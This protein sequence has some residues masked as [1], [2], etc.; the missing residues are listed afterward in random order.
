MS[1]RSLTLIVVL[2][3]SV[4][5][6][7][8]GMIWGQ[9]STATLQGVIIDP[10]GTLVPR[11]VVKVQ[12][13]GTGLER[14]TQTEE[15]GTY[16]L[17]FLPV[18]AYTVIVEASGFKQARVQNVVLEIGQTRTLD[19]R[20]EVGEMQ[21]T[22]DV[23]ET[24]PPL[25][26]NSAVIGTVIQ[27]SQVK[28][29]PLN[30]RHWASLMMLAP[31]AINT[32]EGNQLSIRFVGRARDDNN[33]T[34]DSVDAT[35]AKDPRQETAVRLIISMDAISEFRVNSTLY[36]ADSGSGAGGQVQLIS[37]GGTNRFHGSVFE[38][39]RNDAFD[40]RIFTDPG[41]LPPFRLNQ[42]G[43][44]F[45]GPLRKDKTFFFVNYEGIRQHQGLTL[46]DFVP[47][48]AFRAAV[49]ST[50]PS[51]ATIV[52]G[53]PVGTLRTVDPN[54]DEIVTARTLKTR[55]DSGVFRFDHRF[56]D[57]SSFYAR[58]SVD[59]AVVK[60][61]LD[62]GIGL[63]SDRVR[64]SNAALQFQRIFTPT[65]VNETIIGMNRSPLLR[66]T[67]GPFLERFA[68]PG[69]MTLT[70]NQ[71]VVE[72]GTSFTAMDSLAITRGRHNLKV[73]GELRRI[74][75]NVGEGDTTSISYSS[76]PD[77]QANR[78]NSF[79]IT[80]FPV[81]GVGHDPSADG[82]RRLRQ[83]RIVTRLRALIQ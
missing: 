58:Y 31:G 1:S 14:E 24:S 56:S 32:G 37:R 34:F 57:K 19:V 74:H 69:F 21:Q 77:F 44:N 59:D 18:G 67:T 68:V 81:R 47:S 15:S 75:V 49:A 43:G 23:V 16:A 17:N 48:A 61:P 7:A 64:P 42:F 28:E 73:G 3:L 9:T 40:A 8:G 46:P 55:E 12:H 39:L 38:F 76:R 83:P 41:E 26:R 66:I 35:G 2:S 51:L 78:M 53:Y 54:I 62:P 45:G 22:V 4:L 33:W 52:S 79:S 36:S 60:T 71:E 63:R 50:S 6:L 30:G 13:L 82:R 11:A 27:S 65:V 5:V 29:L 25:D 10:A 70:P 20:L 80:P 72:A